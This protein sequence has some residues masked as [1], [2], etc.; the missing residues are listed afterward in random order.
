VQYSECFGDDDFVFGHPAIRCQ[1]PQI[2]I[3]RI[4]C[5]A[6]QDNVSLNLGSVVLEASRNLGGGTR[7]K[8]EFSTECLAD[9]TFDLYTG[10]IICLEATNP[11]G[12]CLS[13]NKIIPLPRLDFASSSGQEYMDYYKCGPNYMDASDTASGLKLFVVAGP[14]VTNQ[15]LS[16]EPLQELTEQ[17]EK[18]LPDVVIMLGPFVDGEHPILAQG[19]VDMD[20]NQVFREAVTPCIVKM[21]QAKPSIEICLIPSLKDSCHPWVA[22]PQPPLGATLENDKYS[23]MRELGLISRDGEI[24]ANLFPNPVQ[25]TVNEVVIAISNNDIVADLFKRQMGRI[26]DRFGSVF[27]HILDQR[28]FYPLFPPSSNACLDSS[29]ALGSQPT[30]PCVL[31]V[32][33]DILILPSQMST[34]IQK[35]DGVLCVNPGWLCKQ[36]AYGSYATL[37]IHCLNTESMTEGDVFDHN[38]ADRTRAAIVKI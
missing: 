25:F 30:D 37:D 8:V 3:G 21:K 33:P 19:K 38:V 29:R 20:V 13:V 27:S 35:L 2:Y 28:H 32:K 9:P 23:K 4:S 12:S 5:D 18:Q 7:T 26:K 6:L 16:F 17:I 36:Q 15:S 31:Q 22:Y 10:R 24:L 14:Y 11:T 34:T 1:E